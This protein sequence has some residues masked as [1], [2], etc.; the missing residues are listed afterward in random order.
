MK[1]LLI[2]LRYLSAIAIYMQKKK[3]LLQ[4]NVIG[5]NQMI[6]T[7]TLHSCIKTTHMCMSIQRNS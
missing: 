2:Y 1:K 7:T 5:I 3:N 6:V 4:L